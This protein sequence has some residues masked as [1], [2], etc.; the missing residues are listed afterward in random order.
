MMKILL[1][2]SF[3]LKLNAFVLIAHKGLHNN[4]PNKFGECSTLFL[5]DMGIRHGENT[6]HAVKGALDNGATMA[7]I[8]FRPTK[9]DKLV[10]FHDEKLDCKTNGKGMVKDHT[11]YELKKLDAY[12]SLSF[13][14]GKT[15]PLRGKGIGEIRTLEEYIKLFP[16]TPFHFNPKEK[17]RK[18]YDLLIRVLE[19][20]PKK[21]RSQSVFWGAY[22]Q[23]MGI[24]IKF[25]E[26][27]PFLTND[28]QTMKCMNYLKLWGIISQWSGLPEYCLNFKDITIDLDEHFPLGLDYM[29]RIFTF[30]NINLWGYNLRELYQYERLKKLNW[31]GALT[32]NIRK[33]N[34]RK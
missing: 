29:T 8:D 34:V 7:E 17:S 3:C 26:F 13:D 33:F 12:Y 4:H 23:Y 20:M 9:D 16:N 19:L 11:S 18:E 14:G 10:V 32:P 27:G 30:Y 22:P 28:W 24:K 15:Y 21:V 31:S 2:L 1:F 5:K 25:P 6:I